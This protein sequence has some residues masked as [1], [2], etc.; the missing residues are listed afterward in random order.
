MT[1]SKK[2]L[3]VYYSNCKSL[4]GEV[5]HKIALDIRGDIY[6]V[7]TT[8]KMSHQDLHKDGRK[9]FSKIQI[10]YEGIDFSPYNEIFIGGEWCGKHVIGP[11]RS[12]IIQNKS[13]IIRDDLRL[14]FFALDKNGDNIEKTFKEMTKMIKEP[15]HK[16]NISP[17]DYP[18]HEITNKIGYHAIRSREEKKEM[19]EE[20]KEEI[21]QP[22]SEQEIAFVEKHSEKEKVKEKEPE[23]IKRTV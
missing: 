7:R 2:P 19:K 14:V 12:W 15:D 10:V 21:K 3:V 13:N 6:E 8:K 22:K 11:M 17:E 1:D 20:M 16:L 5:A 4:M 18:Y 23:G 9:T